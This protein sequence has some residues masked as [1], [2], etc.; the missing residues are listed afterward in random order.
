MQFVKRLPLMAMEFVKRPTLV[1]MKFVKRRKL[2]RVKIRTF[3]RRICL[4]ISPR[5]SL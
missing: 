4:W 3:E 2:L 1:G 5:V